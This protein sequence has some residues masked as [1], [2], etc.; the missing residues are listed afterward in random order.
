MRVGLNG[1]LREPRAPD[2]EGVIAEGLRRQK[3]AASE[4]LARLIEALGRDGLRPLAVAV[5]VGRGFVYGNLEIIFAYDSHVRVAEGLAV[6]DAIRSALASH[7]LRW[8]D[9][10]EKSVMDVAARKFELSQDDMAALLAAFGAAAG[11]P[12][13]RDHKHAALAAWIALAD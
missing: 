1:L 4:S 9:V 3:A 8:G 10:D 6:R 5:L 11:R 13:R 2:P 7:D 12:W